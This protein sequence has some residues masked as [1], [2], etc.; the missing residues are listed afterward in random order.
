MMTVYKEPGSPTYVPQHFHYL[1]TDDLTD[2]QK[3]KERQKDEERRIAFA[4]KRKA[5][6]ATTKRAIRKSPKR[7][8]RK[9]SPD[10][11]DPSMEKMRLAYEDAHRNRPQI[12]VMS[13]HSLEN[14]TRDRGRKGNLARR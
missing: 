11:S 5:K 6:A 2:E 13:T 7:P 14:M 10:K 9:P 8:P 3:E 1:P 4:I 12:H